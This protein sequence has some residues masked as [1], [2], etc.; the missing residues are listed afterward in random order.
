VLGASNVCEGCGRTLDEIA[1][2]PD[3]DIEARRA[4]LARAASR[5]RAK[6]GG[7]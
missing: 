6:G 5:L 2:W 7:D 1:A 4:T 3:A